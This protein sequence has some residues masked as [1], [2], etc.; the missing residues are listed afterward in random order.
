MHRAAPDCECTGET[1]ERLRSEHPDFTSSEHRHYGGSADDSRISVTEILQTDPKQGIDWLLSYGG[2][3]DEH[4]RLIFVQSVT[5]A[6]A[7]DQNWGWQLLYSLKE[8]AAWNSGLWDGL[9]AGLAQSNK[10]LKQL[11]SVILFLENNTD[12]LQNIPPVLQFLKSTVANAE[13]TGALPLSLLKRTEKLFSA[14]WD[15]A[16]QTAE[17]VTPGTGGWFFAIQ[18]H[19][20][21]AAAKFWVD[22]KSVV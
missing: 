10:T 7:Q 21:G 19:I 17:N 18:D 11:R 9:L 6:V 5:E 1:F 12:L 3:T 13:V 4:H 16:S 2:A 20:G 8:I 15:R 22:R 14:L